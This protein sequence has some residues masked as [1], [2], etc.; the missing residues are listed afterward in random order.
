MKITV[1]TIESKED[2]ERAL[3]EMERLDSGPGRRRS[4]ATLARL[5]VLGAL[6]EA[7]E[8]EHFPMPAPDPI[9][10]IRFYLEQ[11][12]TDE[13]ELI[14]VIGSRARVW[15]VLNRKRPLT[16]E[17]IRRL[18]DLGIPAEALLGAA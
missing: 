15:E 12:G 16:L 3:S 1:S 5:S 14:G 4:A 9:E 6:V 13:S 7:Y 2:Y 17:M 18:R 10:V 11:N 8:E